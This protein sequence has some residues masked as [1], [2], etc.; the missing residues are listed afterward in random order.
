MILRLYDNIVGVAG[1]TLDENRRSAVAGKPIKLLA[2]VAFEFGVHRYGLP[3]RLAPH[4]TGG[5]SRTRIMVSERRLPVRCW[6]R[7]RGAIDRLL[8]TGVR[9]P[10]SRSVGVSIGFRRRVA[11]ARREIAAGRD[12]R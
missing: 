6:I 1:A 7:L 12:T 8:A 4:P 11:V 9:V 3:R 10:Q 5:C 2:G